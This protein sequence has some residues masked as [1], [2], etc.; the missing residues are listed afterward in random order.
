MVKPSLPFR[1][2]GKY[3]DKQVLAILPRYDAFLQL[4]G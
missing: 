1:H 2:F 4:N 3:C